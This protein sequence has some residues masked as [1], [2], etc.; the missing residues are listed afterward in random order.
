M[1]AKVFP[2]SPSADRV[3]RM[4][5][6]FNQAIRRISTTGTLLL[7]VFGL[8]ICCCN[9]RQLVLM[10]SDGG[11]VQ[12]TGCSASATPTALPSCCSG[13]D[14]STSS[15]EGSDDGVSGSEHDTELPDRRC[16]M[17]CCI[18]GS[19][20]DLSPQLVAVMIPLEAPV[21]PW[22]GVVQSETDDIIWQTSWLS[23]ADGIPDRPLYQQHCALRL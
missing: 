2:C 6:T 12:T 22:V 14:P 18:K 20:L 11:A 10:A 16:C 3:R 8:S 5:R 19:G 9:M 7:L 21:L 13:C 1:G 23:R 4:E 17:Q 15:R